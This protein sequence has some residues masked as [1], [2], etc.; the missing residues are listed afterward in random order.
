MN[1]KFHCHKLLIR[2]AILGAFLG[3]G[4]FAVIEDGPRSLS[5]APLAAQSTPEHA[6]NG[7]IQDP[8]ASSTPPA[9]LGAENRAEPALKARD[10]AA[11]QTVEKL[12]DEEKYEAAAA[13]AARIREEARRAGNVTLWTWALIKEGQLRTALH[14]YE[15]AVRFF[16]EQPWPDSPLERD[17]LDLFFAQSLVTYYHAYSWEVNRRERVEAKGPI[18]LN[19]WTKDQ[20]FDEAWKSLLRIWKDRAR[21]A[22]HKAAQF[23]DFWSPGD[24]P[25]GVRDSLRDA[26]VYLMVRLLADTGF[27]TPRQTNEAWL[28]NLPNLLAQAGKP[29]SPDATARVLESAE[30]HPVDKTCALLGEHEAWNRRSSRPE[31]ALEA[32][33]E[34]IKT[35]HEA[36]DADENRLLIRTHLAEFLPSQ[37]KHA[38]WAVGQA[39]LAEY[40]REENAPDALVRARKLAADGSERYPLSPGGKHCLHILKSIEAPDYSLKAMRLDA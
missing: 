19:S 15:T 1:S 32:R 22:G 33:F 10:R 23:P 14:G 31:A 27:W 8:S 40:T 34:L 26:V 24:Y 20:I 3:I 28:L 13:E 38:W 37:R 9:D 7:S 12:I 11:R 16:K 5:C 2:V 4:L 21:L 36:F 39:L 25:V 29:G 6:K 18:D 35:L 30:S 17:M